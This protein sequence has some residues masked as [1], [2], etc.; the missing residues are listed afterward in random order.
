MAPPAVL[1]K[2]DY[3]PDERVK[4]IR[5]GF[6]SASVFNLIHYKDFN[7]CVGCAVMKRTQEKLGLE[8]PEECSKCFEEL[9]WRP[10]SGAKTLALATPDDIPTRSAIADDSGLLDSNAPTGSDLS[11]IIETISAALLATPSGESAVAQPTSTN[12]EP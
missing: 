8:L 11:V 7:S 12:R 10:S 1:S 3:T 6:E 5:N 4:A 2:L 9:C